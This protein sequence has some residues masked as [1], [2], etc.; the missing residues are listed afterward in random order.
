MSICEPTSGNRG[1]RSNEDILTKIIPWLFIIRYSELLTH[2][3]RFWFFIKDFPL[4]RLQDFF[5]EIIVLKYLCLGRFCSVHKA[6]DV[7]ID[8]SDCPWVSVLRKTLD[9]H[10]DKISLMPSDM[11][12]QHIDGDAFQKHVQSPIWF[13]YLFWRLT[14]FLYS[15][16]SPVNFICKKSTVNFDGLVQDC[17]I[18]IALAMEILQC[19][20]KPS[21]GDTAVLC[22]VDECEALRL[23]NKNGSL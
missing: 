5:N 16:Q 18:S 10:A 11:K 20:T 12:H 14:I 21:N 8:P 9:R 13:S 4:L 19:C 1:V 7:P 23:R 22:R 6:N 15:F 2:K 17:S 3:N